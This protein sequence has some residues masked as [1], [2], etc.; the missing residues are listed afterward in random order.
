MSKNYT[1][2]HCLKTQIESQQQ[3]IRFH[4]REVWWISLGKNIGVELDG[5]NALFDRPVLIFRKFNHL[6]CWI[7]PLTSKQR[8]DKFHCSFV[9]KHRI[10]YAVLSQIRVISAKRLIRRIG[11]ISHSDF[12]KISLSF[13]QLLKQTD[14]TLG[15]SGA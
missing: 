1:D 8:D 9:L 4:E 11:R 2:W 5:K 14:P 15:S 7:L 10:Q 12:L 6:M 13:D 3:L